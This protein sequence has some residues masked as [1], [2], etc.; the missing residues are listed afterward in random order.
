[1]TAGIEPATS[2]VTDQ[3][4]SHLN[5]A[6][7]YSDL[8]LLHYLEE[9]GIRIGRRRLF[10]LLYTSTFWLFCLPMLHTIHLLWWRL[11][12]LNPIPFQFKIEV[13]DEE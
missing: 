3:C 10:L 6:T 7:E 13:S 12:D 4:S 8:V 11:R 5:Y 1:M 2:D 9:D